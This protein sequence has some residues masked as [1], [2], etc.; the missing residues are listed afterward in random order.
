MK[1]AGSDLSDMLEMKY[2]FIAKKELFLY[3]LLQCN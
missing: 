3:Q 2:V 1:N